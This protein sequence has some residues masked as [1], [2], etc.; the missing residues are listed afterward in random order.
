MA[1][2][3]ATAAEQK[4]MEERALSVFASERKEDMT[5]LIIAFALAIFVIIALK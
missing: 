4:Q 2:E 3:K 5:A 1:E